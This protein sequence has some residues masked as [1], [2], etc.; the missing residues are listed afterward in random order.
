[1]YPTLGVSQAFASPMYR[2]IPTMQDQSYGTDLSQDK[3]LKIEE[4]KRLMNKYPQYHT[5]PGDIIR[6]AIFN[7]I[8]GDDTLLDQVRTAWCY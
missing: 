1:M 5:N 7:S 2:P 6:L 3:I 8:N 4:L